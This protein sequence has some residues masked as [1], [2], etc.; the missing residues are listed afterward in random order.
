MKY[1]IHN[2]NSKLLITNFN[3]L[4]V[5]LKSYEINKNIY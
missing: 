4:Q 2:L 3:V 5:G 1:M